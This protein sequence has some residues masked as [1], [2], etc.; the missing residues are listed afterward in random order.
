VNDVGPGDRSYRGG[1]SEF[2]ALITVVRQ[3]PSRCAIRAFGTPSAASLAWQ[4]LLAGP[5]LTGGDHPSAEAAASAPL[6]A[7][8]GWWLARRGR[9]ANTVIRERRS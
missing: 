1:P 8:I 4:G 3:I 6:G 9:T 2:T 5:D 7:L